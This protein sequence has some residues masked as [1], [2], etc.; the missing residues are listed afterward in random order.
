MI[1]Q[2]RKHHSH[3]TLRIQVERFDFQ[4]ALACHLILSSYQ[5]W[6]SCRLGIPNPTPQ[7]ED[8]AQACQ[9]LYGEGDDW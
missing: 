3:K 4:R 7:A 8:W 2:G 5:S 9:V 1:S 6:K